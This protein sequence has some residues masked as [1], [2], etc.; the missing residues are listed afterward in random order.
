MGFSARLYGGDREMRLLQEL[1][2]GLGG[3]RILRALAINPAI[4]HANEGHTSFM[5]V[6]RMR[7]LVQKGITLD[8]ATNSVRASTVFTTHTPVPAG[9]DAFSIDLVDKYFHNYWGQLGLD[10]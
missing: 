10:R 6:E 4:W 3:V 1:V 5:M 7:E 2:I 9:N 8:D